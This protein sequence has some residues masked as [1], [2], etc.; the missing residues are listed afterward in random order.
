MSSIKMKKRLSLL[1]AIIMMFT[2]MPT[3]IFTL[4]ASESAPVMKQYGAGT[5]DYRSYYN[6]IYSATFLNVLDWDDV[7]APDTVAY[8]DSSANGDKFTSCA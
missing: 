5:V 4:G 3:T 6:S 7:N 2:M 1:L 8:W